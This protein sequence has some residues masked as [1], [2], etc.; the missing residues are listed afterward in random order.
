MEAEKVRRRNAARVAG[1][2]DTT[3]T[4]D[5]LREH[6]CKWFNILNDLIFVMEHA[7]SWPVPGDGTHAAAVTP[8]RKKRAAERDEGS[9]PRKKSKSKSS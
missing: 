3:L 7:Q 5:D 8:V 2:E 1:K 9:S 6:D 4:F